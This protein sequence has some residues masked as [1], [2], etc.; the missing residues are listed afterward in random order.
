MDG[1]AAN[2]HLR[3]QA[4]LLATALVVPL[5]MAQRGRQDADHQQR[6]T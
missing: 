5:S 6:N 1:Y 4:E 2:V 3:P